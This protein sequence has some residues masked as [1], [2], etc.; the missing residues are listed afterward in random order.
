MDM[1]VS[2]KNKQELAGLGVGV[3]YLY[4][5]RAQGT[6]RETSDYDVG[7]VFKDAAKRILVQTA[8]APSMVS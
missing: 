1:R 6:A 4:G 8:T 5:S 3:L 2:A 7:V